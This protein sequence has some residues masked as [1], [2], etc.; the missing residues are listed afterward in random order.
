MKRTKIV[1]TIGPASE[2]EEV[3]E[4]LMKNGMNVARINTSHGDEQEQ[5][6]KIERIKRLRERLSLPIGILLDLAGPKIRTGYLE[7]DEIC[8]EEGQ[9]LTLTTEDIRGNEKVISISY[10]GLPADVKKGDRVLLSDGAI[11]LEVLDTDG[12]KLIKTVVKNGGVIT[13]RRGVNVPGVDLKGISSITERDRAYIEFGVKMGVDMF[14]LSFVRKAED[15]LLAKELIK[16]AGG[17]QPVISKIETLQ[18]LDNLDEIIQVSDGVMV[19]RGDL[20]VEIPLEEVP[21]AQKRIIGMANRCAKPVITATQMLESMV[22]N[23]RPTRAEV[24]DVANAIL[25][26]TDAIMLSEETA[27]GRHPVEAVKYMARIAQKTEQLFEEL[28][29]LAFDWIRSFAFSMDVSDAISHACWHLSEDL[30]AKVIISFT[31]TGSTARRVS[32]FRPGA[33][34]LA[35]TPEWSTYYRLSVVWG[36][37]PLKIGYA[38]STDEMIDTA[39]R[40]AKEEGY[41][42]SGDTVII[43]AGIPIGQPGTTNMLKVHEV[44]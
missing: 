12:K 36:V 8:L 28:K 34:I 22:E 21:I 17:D 3:L 14:A 38:S 18:A 4:R 7:K 42:K 23:P 2:S 29:N 41:V 33:L 24:T 44:R 5:G 40:K 37:V 6:R 11:E 15:V 1:C 31:S 27:M 19:A 32:R 26:G 35:P 16:Q 10:K 43:T 13:H 25:D 30:S 20:G 9:E 39:I